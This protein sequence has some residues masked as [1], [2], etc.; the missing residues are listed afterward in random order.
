MDIV[1]RIY[2]GWRDLM[3]NKSDPRTKNWFLMDSP[4]PTIL[5]SAI[6]IFSV[7][8]IGPQIMKNRKP[9]NAKKLQLYYNVFHLI[10]NIYLFYE[11]CTNGWLVNYSFRCQPVDF[12]MSGTPY[13]IARGCWLYYMSKFTDFFETCIFVLLKRF[14]MI[15][16]YHVAHHSIMPVSVWFGV[17]FL[18]GGHSTFFGFLNTFV[19]IVIYTYFVTITFFPKTKTT[20][21]KWWKPFYPYFQIAQFTLIFIHAFQLVFSN[22]CN[23]PM[24]FVYF[25]GF[26]ALLFYVLVRSKMKTDKLKLVQLQ[27]QKKERFNNNEENEKFKIIEETKELTSD[28]IRYRIL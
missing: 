4:F 19:H 13:R 28:T 15:N 11:A 6:Y 2:E 25:I 26:H 14:D 20:I 5:I 8:I 9:Y 12:S 1:N 18:A 27:K 3:D 10:I 23:Y 22:E 24:S 17:K 7:K 16:L 21:F